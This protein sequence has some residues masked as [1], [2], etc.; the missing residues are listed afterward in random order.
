MQ[1]NIGVHMLKIAVVTGAN[2]GLGFE[3]TGKLLLEGY[4]VYMFCRSFPK[5]E[6]ARNRLTNPENAKVIQVD[7][8]DSES[9]V[10][11]CQK[12]VEERTYIDVLINNAAVNIEVDETFDSFSINACESTLNTNVIGPMLMCR[13]LLPL[14]RNSFDGRVV[15]ISSSFAQLT[16]PRNEILA[17][18]SVSK[19]A[20]NALT[21]NLAC[22]EG[23][24]GVFVF[25]VDPG[26][27]KTDM[28]GETAE[29]EVAD[30]A[31]D[32]LWLLC[33]RRSE[34]KTGSFYKNRNLCSW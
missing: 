7:L 34:L 4:Y 28:G 19:T 9:V 18:Y 24:D 3:L 17:L 27:M 31:D 33:E 1:N 13:E 32:V 26:W 23:E 22:Q 15:N 16:V 12:L 10:E 29:C 5:G 25:S 2:R 20:L 14:L 8:S 30:S 11:A 21:V 6:D